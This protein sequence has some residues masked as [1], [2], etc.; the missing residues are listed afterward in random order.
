M[1]VLVTGAA[2]GLGLEFARHLVAEGAQV[3]GADLLEAPDAG[4]PLVRTDVSSAP[5]TEALA[6]V[7]QEVLG[8][9]DVLINNAAVVDLARRPFWEIEPE[10]WDR[11]MAVNVRGTWLCT[12]ALLPLLRASE[13]GAVVNVASEVAFSG[14]TGLAHY[15]ASK[16]AVVSLTR[17]LARELGPDGIRVNA[18]APGYIPTEAASTMAPDGYD[19]SGTPLGRVAMPK[20]L[21]GA[22][23]FLISDAS[24]F[25]TGQTL[26]VNGGRLMG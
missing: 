26:L 12:R 19:A 22:L 14:S 24:A 8:G 23:T 21:L 1:R 13:E 10:E 9:L 15:V 16:G 5:D 11:V 17:A 25:V 7:T 20:D 6:S 3:L 2:R 18:I 4:F